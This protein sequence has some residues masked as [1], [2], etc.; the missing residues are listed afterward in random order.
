MPPP[1]GRRGRDEGD[2]ADGDRRRAA[3]CACLAGRSVRAAG[4]LAPARGQGAGRPAGRAQRGRD[5]GRPRRAGGRA[6]EPGRRHPRHAPP[7]GLRLRPPGRLRPG[8][9]AGAG[10]RQ[11]GRGRGRA[12]LHLPSA[13][14]P[15]LVGRRA[16]HD[17]GL[18]LLVAGRRN[19]RAA[20]P[21]RP[22]ARPRGRGRAAD[23]RDPG[24]ADRAL[25]LVQAQP[26]LPAGAR[27]GAAAVHLRA[28]PLPQAVPRRLRPTRRSSPA[29]S[30]ATGR[31]TGPSSTAGATT[32]TASTTRTCRRSSPG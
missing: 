22:A 15:P 30:R 10:H 5:R 19:P 32:C 3:S 29:W 12:D 24:R 18:P 25:F 13:R 31:A 23:G 2:E 1:R 20:E 8:P 28:R 7:G 26:V 9:R 11:G 14:R 16:V 17:R 21:G 4:A 6:Q 27:R